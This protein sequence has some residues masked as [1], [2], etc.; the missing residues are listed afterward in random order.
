MQ[1]SVAQLVRA[2]E[3]GMAYRL[4]IADNRLPISDQ[5]RL[6]IT[7]ILSEFY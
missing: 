6:P 3:P 1:V 2:S 4:N 7:D 5:S